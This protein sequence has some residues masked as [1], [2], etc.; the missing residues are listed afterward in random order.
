MYPGLYWNEFYKVY[1]RTSVFVSFETYPIFN[2]YYVPWLAD[3][4][5]FKRFSL[6]KFKRLFYSREINH[7]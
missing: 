1:I 2:T 6:L 4:K 5:K 7:M 3:K